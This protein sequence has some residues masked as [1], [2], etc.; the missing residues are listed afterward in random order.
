MGFDLLVK[1]V[2]LRKGSTEFYKNSSSVEIII[3][4]DPYKVLAAASP[5]KEEMFATKNDH[6]V[7]R[8]F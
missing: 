4:Q 8:T 3:T 6:S 5:Y 2:Y 1:P 7:W